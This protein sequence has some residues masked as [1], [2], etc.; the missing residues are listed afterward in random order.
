M[1]G[2][3]LTYFKSYDQIIEHALSALGEGINHRPCIGIAGE[4]G[5]GKSSLAHAFKIYIERE[6][7][8]KVLVLHQDDYFHLPPKDNHNKRLKDITHVGPQ[9]VDLSTMKQN[10]LAF[11]G[12]LSSAKKPLVDYHKNT[13]TTV[14]IAPRDYDVCV[15]EGTYALHLDPLDLKIFM[16]KTYLETKVLREKRGRDEMS[17]FNEQVLNIEH[18]IVKKQYDNAQLIV[19]NDLTTTKR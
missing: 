7:S 3:T 13:I 17:N 5:C 10:L 4:S 18:H 1:I 6:Y 15:V 9:E 14:D 2:D 16:E 11:K 8:K 12:D 19:H